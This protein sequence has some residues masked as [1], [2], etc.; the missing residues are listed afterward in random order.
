MPA[1]NKSKRNYKPTRKDAWTKDAV[2]FVFSDYMQGLTKVL[3]KLRA[4]ANEISHMSKYRLVQISVVNQSHNHN[5][6]SQMG[7]SKLKTP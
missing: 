4:E 7:S 2:F 6:V 3:S 5:T 1:V